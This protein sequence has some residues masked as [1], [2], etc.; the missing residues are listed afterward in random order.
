MPIDFFINNCK[1]SSNLAEFG[2]CDNPPPT[3]NPKAHIDEVDDTKWIGIVRNKDNKEV[4]FIA[5]DA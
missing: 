3:D 1:S 5:I 2:L 4:D